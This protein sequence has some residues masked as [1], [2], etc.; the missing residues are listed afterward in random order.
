[1]PFGFL[2]KRPDDQGQG[3]DAEQAGGAPR[4]AAAA[5][6]GVSFEAITEDWRLNGQ[7][8]IEGRLSDA[9]NQGEKL[10]IHDVRWGS[11]EAGATLEPAPGFQS[12]DPYDLILVTAGDESL[13]PLTDAERAALVIQKTPFQVAL[14]VPP[15]RVVGTVYLFPGSGPERL[16]D[17]SAGMFL[18]VTNAAATLDG[19][20]VTD[21]DADV[22][23][24]NRYYLRGVEQVEP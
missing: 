6:R 23:L 16:M 1:V 17:R 9:L 11:P 18:P 8:D 5:R 2:K 15:Y 3:P 24:V 10:A 7:M 4:P 22:L 21:P 14:E 20:K 19:V 12:V 13:P